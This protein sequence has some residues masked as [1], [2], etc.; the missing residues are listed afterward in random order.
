MSHRR[1]KSRLLQQYL[2]KQTYKFL[3]MLMKELRSEQLINGLLQKLRV[4]LDSIFLLV[5]QH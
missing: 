1:L 5:T 3:L 2:L 4:N